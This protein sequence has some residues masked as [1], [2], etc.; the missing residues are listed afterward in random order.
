MWLWFALLSFES[1]GLCFL[2]CFATPHKLAIVLRLVGTIVLDAFCLLDS[3]QK[4]QMFPFSA[5]LILGNAL[6]HIGISDSRKRD[7]IMLS[8]EDLVF[9]E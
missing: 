6:V 5:V 7:K 3:A 4:C 9:K 1:W 8:T 2:I